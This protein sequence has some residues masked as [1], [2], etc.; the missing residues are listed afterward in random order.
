VRSELQKSS[1]MSKHPIH[2]REN[3]LSL[4]QYEYDSERNMYVSYEKFGDD[5]LTVSRA[6][7]PDIISN[8]KN[9]GQTEMLVMVEV[10]RMIFMTQNIFFHAILAQYVLIF[11]RLLQYQRPT[12]QF[13]K[14]CGGAQQ[15]LHFQIHQELMW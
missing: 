7:I 12:V 5:S 6:T 11:N 14:A 10:S 1:N 9:D 8:E 2:P 15:K 4:F 3:P 13:D